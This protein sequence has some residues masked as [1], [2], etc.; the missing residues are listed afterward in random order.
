[1]ENQEQ[2]KYL[3]LQNMSSEQQNVFSPTDHKRYSLEGHCTGVFTE[4]ISRL[5]LDQRSRYVRIFTP[6]KMPEP[7]DGDIKVWIANV[8]GNP[9]LPESLTNAKGETVPN[10]NRKPITLHHIRRTDQIKINDK[11]ALNMPPIQVVIPPYTRLQVSKSDAEWLQNRDGNQPN[12]GVGKLIICRAP[13][14]DE[15]NETWTYDEVRAFAMLIDDK[16]IDYVSEFPDKKAFSGKEQEEKT[17]MQLLQLLF[18]RIVDDRYNIPPK[19]AVDDFLNKVRPKT[20]DVSQN[21]KT[22]N[23]T[24]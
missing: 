16:Y 7:K 9:F 23:A 13:H 2:V 21:L 4:E 20:K 1:M 12:T 24:M 5:F 18:F 14:Q 3:T 19:A 22:Q 6:V 10:E 11:E 17:K 15:P 8:T